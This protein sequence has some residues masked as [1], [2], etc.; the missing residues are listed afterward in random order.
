MCTRGVCM[1]QVGKFNF[2]TQNL[3]APLRA[4]STFIL[5]VCTL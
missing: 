5:T 1:G 2:C 4:S 3:I